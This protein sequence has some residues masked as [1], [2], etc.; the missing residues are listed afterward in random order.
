M[1][2]NIKLIIDNVSGG[3]IENENLNKDTTE[4]RIDSKIFA[5][6]PGNS[7]ETSGNTKS[8]MP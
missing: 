8:L 6:L 2:N 3:K 7:E 1:N 4:R 5:T